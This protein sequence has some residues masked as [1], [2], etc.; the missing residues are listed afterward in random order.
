MIIIETFERWRQPRAPP[1]RTP[2]NREKFAVTRHG[3]PQFPAAAS[4]L[5]PTIEFA[6]SVVS[7]APKPPLASDPHRQR[8]QIQRQFRQIASRPTLLTARRN[9]ASLNRKQKY[10]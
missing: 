7:D 6:P 5:R 4:S 10:P 9:C 2:T 3:P 1:H 8:H